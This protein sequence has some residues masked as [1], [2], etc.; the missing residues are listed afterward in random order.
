MSEE[1]KKIEALK[2]AEDTEEERSAMTFEEELLVR[3]GQHIQTL[4]SF[5]SQINRLRYTNKELAFK[6]DLHSAMAADISI[7]LFGSTGIDAPDLLSK[8]HDLWALTKLEI[9]ETYVEACHRFYKKSLQ[10]RFAT[11][12]KDF[13]SSLSVQATTRKAEKDTKK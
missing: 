9:G 8:A 2:E 11:S 13:L 12:W 3:F 7:A 5:Q 6:F 4:Y 1:R 10:E